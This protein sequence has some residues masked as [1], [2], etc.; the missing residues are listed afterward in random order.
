MAL[1]K[2]CNKAEQA[3]RKFRGKQSDFCTPSCGQKARRKLAGRQV[4][5]ACKRCSAPLPERPEGKTGRDVLYCSDFCYEAMY[6][7]R[8]RSRKPFQFPERLLR[9][10]AFLEKNRA[11]FLRPGAR[12][13]DRKMG[14]YAV[15]PTEDD[16]VVCYV[17][18]T[19]ECETEHS[20]FDEAR[21]EY[22][23]RTKRMSA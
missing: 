6:R 10:E 13:A 1:C 20:E 19:R 11:G 2:H 3:I 7:E 21:V 18:S 22:L 15:E 5:V 16:A 12:N 14:V 8:L 4:P 9:G 23:L 17:V